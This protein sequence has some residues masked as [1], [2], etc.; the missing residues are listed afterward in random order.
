M[1]KTEIL[2]IADALPYDKINHAGGKTF[3][4][5]F[6]RLLTNSRYRLSVIGICKADELGKLDCK[7]YGFR[8]IPIITKGNVIRNAYRVLYDVI[9]KAFSLESYG[10]PYYKTKK[11]L[12]SAKK[13][14]EKGFNPDI[15]FLE[16]TNCVLMVDGIKKIFPKARIV[17]SE[18][19]VSF[20]GIERKIRQARGKEKENLKKYY[21][22]YKKKEIDALKM[23]D[24]ALPESEK[25]RQLLLDGG[26]KSDKVGVLVPYYH[27]MSDCI[28][29]QYNHDVLFW[30]AMYRPENY[31]AAL[32]FIENVMP[33]LEDTD[34]RFVVAG[35][36]PPDKLLEKQ[37]DRVI[38][39][40]FV[41]DET[42]MFEH[43]LCF[44]SPLLTGAGIK[45]KIIE[46]FSSGIPVLTN[47]IG[48]EGIPALDG[49]SYFH[50]NAP[51]DYESVIRKMM[52][53]EIDMHELEN[54]QRL[55]V[56]QSFDLN[57]SFENYV[58]LINRLKDCV[59]C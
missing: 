2:Y 46:A 4:Y 47:D 42:P 32:W 3:N 8:C 28:R 10:Q 36:N 58:G 57:Q 22:W 41:E 40:G 20:L 48:I 5:Y 31:E 6:K 23:C 51:E 7:Q 50:C 11:I 13:L 59:D 39:T 38:V 19:D 52:N 16:W 37:S 18:Y 25:D 27:D 21:K 30:G 44:V 35:N 55:L 53:N 1:K 14:R 34:V 12:D 17:A 49:V 54:K 43:S 9:G 45:V 56:K 29:N 15:I 26:V 33:L 24:Y